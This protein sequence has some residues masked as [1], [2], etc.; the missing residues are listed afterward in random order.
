MRAPQSRALLAAILIVVALS[1]PFRSALADSGEAPSFPFFPKPSTLVPNVEFWKKVFTEYRIGDFVLH[2]REHLGL[3]YGVVR[4]KETVSQGRAIEL[5]KPEVDRQRAR[6]QAILLGLAQG[7]APDELGPDAAAVFEL[8]GCPCEPEVLL[9]AADNIRA[10]Q[11][12]R[13]KVDEGLA[14]ARALLPRMVAILREHDVPLELAALPLVESGFNPKAYSKVGAA[15]LWQFMRSTGQLYMK[16]TKKRDDRRDPIRAT[17]AAA[18]LLRSNFRALGSW[19]LAI[20]AYN[21]GTEGIQAA[22]VAVG[23][24]AIEDI[25]TGYNGPRFG[26]A[27]KNFYAEFL[28][29]LEVVHPVIL[30]CSVMPQTAPRTAKIKLRHVAYRRS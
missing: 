21:H 6:L 4:V 23:S 30:E 27:S 26:F 3:I 20:I 5:A 15:G 25:I 29:A 24:S 19:P 8:W 13:E 10:Q 14:R 28:A 17:D 22:K 1:V 16:V 11:G 9:H 2:D 18:H 7:S 12:L